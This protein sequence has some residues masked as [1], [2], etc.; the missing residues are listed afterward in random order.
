MASSRAREELLF[1]SKGRRLDTEEP[2]D[3][4][5]SFLPCGLSPRRLPILSE[6]LLVVYISLNRAY[7][8]F[9]NPSSK[10]PNSHHPMRRDLAFSCAL[11]C[12]VFICNL[13]YTRSSPIAISSTVGRRS[14]SL[15]Q[16]AY[17]V[18]PSVIF[19]NDLVRPR[20]ALTISLELL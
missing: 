9:G 11:L 2:Q 13:K 5:F 6:I 12:L 7:K 17:S 10:I 20:S 3:P 19:V 15:N 8:S 4:S 14:F 16:L 1:A 18:R